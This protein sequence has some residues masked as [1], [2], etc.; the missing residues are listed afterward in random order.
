MIL[1]SNLS[2]ET[3][4]AEKGTEILIYFYKSLSPLLFLGWEGSLLGEE[5]EQ[6]HTVGKQ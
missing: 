4:W 6:I 1:D 5:T 2:M 3:I